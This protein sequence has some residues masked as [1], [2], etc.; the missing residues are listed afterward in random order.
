MTGSIS[1]QNMSLQ[2]ELRFTADAYAR[3]YPDHKHTPALLRTA[4]ATIDR[5]RGG[6]E[7]LWPGLVLDLRY[8]EPDDD[9][10]ALQSRVDT[11]RDALSGDD[12]HRAA[13][14]EAINEHI[15]NTTGV[16]P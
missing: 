16:R 3:N 1:K 13:E 10:D 15:A 2:E 12:D 4:A 6:L 11:I 14:Q 7:M 8:A 5:L 9:R